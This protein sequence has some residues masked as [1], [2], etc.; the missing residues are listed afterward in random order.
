M[1]A[2]L[3]A[4]IVN[5]NLASWVVALF[6]CCSVFII[7]SP[8]FLRPT[9]TSSSLYFKVNLRYAVVGIQQAPLINEFK[10]NLRNAIVSIQRARLFN[11]F[12]VFLHH[13][14]ARLRGAHLFYQLFKVNLRHDFHR[15][16]L[17]VNMLK[18]PSLYSTTALT[19]PNDLIQNV[20]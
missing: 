6:C 13:A 9:I 5:G 1:D 20:H 15:L 16:G 11:Q 3:A 19:T 7:F 4:C 14:I 12:K 17:A 2:K 18:Q 10:V 8:A